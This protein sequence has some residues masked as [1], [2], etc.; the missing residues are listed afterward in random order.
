MPDEPV[1]VRVHAVP[2]TFV[3]N[4]D[5]GRVLV[6]VEELSEYLTALRNEK[7][8][9]ARLGMLIHWLEEQRTAALTLREDHFT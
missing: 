4:A 7:P 6:D 8:F 5:S 9:A 3:Y 1:T 2:V